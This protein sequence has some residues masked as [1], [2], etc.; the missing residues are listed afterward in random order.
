MFQEKE[1][2]GEESNNSQENVEKSENFQRKSEAAKFRGFGDEG[3]IEKKKGKRRKLWNGK[4][5]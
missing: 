1:P 4:G 2:E 3:V 5:T